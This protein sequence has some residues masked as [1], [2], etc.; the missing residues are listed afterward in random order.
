MI[1]NVKLIYDLYVY[2]NHTKFN[3]GSTGLSFKDRYI[4]H[5]YSFKHEKSCNATT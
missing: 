4:K 3:V 5:R 1:F 2:E